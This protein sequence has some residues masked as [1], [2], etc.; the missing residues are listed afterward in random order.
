STAVA[1]AS[2]TGTPFEMSVNAVRNA[3]C[4]CPYATVVG[5]G[6]AVFRASYTPIRNTSCGNASNSGA[7]LIWSSKGL[8]AGNCL[9]AS[10]HVLV[11]SPEIVRYFVKS[12]AIL[13]F[14]VVDETPMNQLP[15]G[16]RTLPPWKYGKA[17]TPKSTPLF[18]NSARF[19]VPPA[20]SASCPLAK[21]WGGS[22]WAGPWD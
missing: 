20:K 17:A 2:L 12:E 16:V 3:S 11:P 6:F 19:H 7:L 1:S 8:N 15:V 21:S 13:W 5:L 22:S 4:S 9:F 10:N 18:W 14:A